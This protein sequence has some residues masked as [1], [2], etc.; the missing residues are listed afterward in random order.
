MTTARD[1]ISASRRIL[2]IDSVADNVS[3]EEMGE[4]LSILNAMLDNWNTQKLAIYYM[5]NQV[6]PIQ[7]NQQNY[8]I[9]L[10]DQVI[11]GNL[12]YVTLGTIAITINGTEFDQYINLTQDTSANWTAAN[13][14]LGLN[15]VGYE[16]NTL[17]YKIGDGVTHWTSVPYQIW[18]YIDNAGKAARKIAMAALAN[19]IKGSMSSVVSNATYN[20][21][22]ALTLN[23]NGSGP[24]VVSVLIGGQG[25][26]DTQTYSVTPLP[27][28]HID[29]Y[30]P[31][32]IDNAFTRLTVLSDP[33]DY[34]LE[35]IS[36]QQ[37]QT[38]ARKQLQ[39]NYPQYL[40]YTPTM[41][42][43]TITLWPQPTLAL[44]LGLTQTQQFI[45]VPT[46]DMAVTLPSGYLKAMQ[47]NL[48]LDLAPR[49]GRLGITAPGT[50]L[51]RIATEAMAD[52]KRMNNKMELMDMDNALL[53]GSGAGAYNIYSDTGS[54]W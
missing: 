20:G 49:Y 39:T 22:D 2:N 43:G 47:F 46:I 36:N 8:T 15:V 13:A 54:G 4:G 50:P 42:F 1:I 52:I 40:L 45:N 6:F 11:Q 9:G 3:A 14:I 38:I 21:T 18:T 19:T 35:I 25:G 29:T 37:F 48:A 30:R 26:G 41:P 10:A 32:M 16:T 28:N 44:S 53:I 51:Y 34:Q 24:L 23:N 5:L 7:A 33:I 17:R 31:I 27:A 12:G